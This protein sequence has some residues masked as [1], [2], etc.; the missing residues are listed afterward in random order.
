MNK[1]GR[2]KSNLGFWEKEFRSPAKRLVTRTWVLVV[3]K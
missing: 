2:G 1:M 3:E